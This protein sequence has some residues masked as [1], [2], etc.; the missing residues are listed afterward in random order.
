MACVSAG[1]G[2]GPLGLHSRGLEGVASPVQ[3]GRLV[4]FEP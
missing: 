1:G 4:V 2:A 3:I